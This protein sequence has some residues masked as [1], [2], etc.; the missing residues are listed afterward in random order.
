MIQNKSPL[1]VVESFLAEII[2]ISIIRFN[3]KEGVF[4][5]LSFFPEKLRNPWDSPWDASPKESQA[6][7]AVPSLSHGTQIPGT[8]GTWD[9]NSC[10]SLGQKSLGLESLGQ[11]RLG[12]EVPSHA[13]PWF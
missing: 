8:V 7:F 5:S 9:R 4:K 13:D 10:V 3:N 1:I 11:K 12:L 6:F 2:L